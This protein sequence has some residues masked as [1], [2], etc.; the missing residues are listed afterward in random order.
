MRALAALCATIVAMVCAAVAQADPMTG[1]S[2]T[3]DVSRPVVLTL[4]ALRA[5]PPNT[6]SV[7][8][9]SSGGPQV[10]T[11]EG[12]LLFDV[13]SAAEPTTDAT[14]KNPLVAL[15]ILATGADDYRAAL[16][17]AEISPDFAGTQALVAYTED[18]QPLGGARL[19]VPGDVKGGRYVSDL[20]ELRVMD[21]SP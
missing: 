7:A 21:P 3:G 4:D 16:A 20:T 15:T 11:F 2:V 6:Q 13:I 1:V 12:A 14:R 19:V 18:G 8:F 9:D 10:H 5:Y 17:W